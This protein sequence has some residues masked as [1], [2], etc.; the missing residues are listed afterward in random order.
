LFPL[1]PL[2]RVHEQSIQRSATAGKRSSA[3]RISCR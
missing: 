3:R 2:G 1:E